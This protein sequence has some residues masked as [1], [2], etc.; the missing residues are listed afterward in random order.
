[1]SHL[2]GEKI[3]KFKL[4]YK[5]YEPV[6][7]DLQS[8]LGDFLP[9]LKQKLNLDFV[10]VE[11]IR[12]Y[13]NDRGTIFRFLRKAN[14]D[15]D[16]ASRALMS[17]LRWR[18]ENQV[19]NISIQDI[20]QDFIERGLFFFH[21]TDKYN[22]P[23]AILNLRQYVRE[24][25]SPTMEEV[26][27]YIIFN[28]EV[29]R[30]LLLDKSRESRDGPI[31]QY[32]ILLDL[33]GAGVSALS[34]DLLRVTT[35]VFRHHF[36]GSTGA[37]FVLNYGWMYSGIWKLFKPIL[38][39]DALNRI[40]FLSENKELLNFFDEENVLIEH[41]GSDTYEYDLETYKPYQYYG[42]P[43]PALPILS[44]ITSYDSLCS[45]NDVFFSAPTTPYHSR[46]PTPKPSSPGLD[47]VPNWL[48]MTQV[49]TSPSV[50]I[51]TKPSILSPSPL[52]PTLR[53]SS[54][55]NSPHLRFSP[56]SQ[57]VS[58][59]SSHNHLNHPSLHP[60]TPTI[61]INSVQYPN[62]T[63]L[64]NDSVSTNNISYTQKTQKSRS[65]FYSL[66]SL[67]TELKSYLHKLLRKLIA[68]KVSGVLYYLV[69]M[70]L[71]RGGLVDEFWRFL[72]QQITMQLGWSAH[73]TT[74]LTTA[75]LSAA[76]SGRADNRLLGFY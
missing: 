60:L 36:P 13:I 35:D 69:I 76:L 58:A 2:I 52:R 49:Y 53:H 61:L 42:N 54:S 12:Q 11:R 55:F 5:E 51:D 1:M 26:K 57:D 48:R 6:V 34:L 46:P 14:F 74:A 24:D 27:K 23:C 22:R 32:V 40:F 50:Q 62:T 41:G 4:L 67:S 63:R 37:I 47:H 21:K 16:A 75:A 43:P 73:T 18:V 65:R 15:F 28:A 45:L 30:R 25:G 70:V 71:L 72:T 38:P 31:L 8:V 20:N 7:D 64:R 59:L 10:Q 44:R 66:L 68:R 17:N 33:K 56:I 19:D 9:E 39:E 3:A 29:A